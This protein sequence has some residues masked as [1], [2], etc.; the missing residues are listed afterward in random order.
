MPFLKL[1]FNSL[2]TL[3]AALPA[4]IAQDLPSNVLIKKIEL[5]SH[6]VDGGIIFVHKQLLVQ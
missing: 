5:K 6:F 2:L 1:F 4:L 3:I